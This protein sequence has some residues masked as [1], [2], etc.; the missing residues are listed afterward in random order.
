MPYIGEASNPFGLDD[1]LRQI[2]EEDYQRLRDINDLIEDLVGSLNESDVREVSPAQS[3]RRLITVAVDGGSSLIF[4]QYREIS[5]GMVR[6]SAFCSDLKSQPDP[7]IIVIKNHEVFDILRTSL[8]A[9]DLKNKRRQ[10]IDALFSQSPMK[11]FSELTGIKH[12]DLGDYVYKDLE[13]FSNIIRS[14]LEWAY[15]V[16]IAE[17]YTR[18]KVL[19]VRDGRLEQHGVKQDFV[20]KLKAYFASK[21]T[22][23]VGVVKS[24]KLVR[25]FVAC[26]V[27][28]R[29]LSCYVQRHP[30]YFKIPER[31]MKYTFR[32]ERQWN[33]DFDESFVFGYRYLGKFLTETFHPMQAVITFDIPWYLDSDSKAVAEIVSTLFKHRSVL[34]G[35]SISAVSEAHAR[36]SIDSSIARTIEAELRVRI[37]RETGLK[38]P[39]W[40]V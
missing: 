14:V 31:L 10:Y 12:E 38:I 25:E 15:I 1:F 33:P 28:Q 34:Y 3:H 11:E 6:V 24:S 18:L 30:I 7:A 36:A 17:E 29:W 21:Q 20:N 27:L 37:E 8:S 2:R 26:S 5:F 35:G 39:D 19:L 32:F 23:I 9:E 13:S 16:N 40:E 22:Y 4:P